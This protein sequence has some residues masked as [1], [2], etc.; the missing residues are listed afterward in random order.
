MKKATLILVL[1]FA[2]IQT[3]AQ[4]LHWL[5]NEGA[6]MSMEFFKHNFADIVENALK[7]Y[8][9][10]SDFRNCDGESIEDLDCKANDIIIYCQTATSYNETRLQE[11]YNQ[12][13]DHN[14]KLL[15]VLLMQFD[16]N[17][18]SDTQDDNTSDVYVA[19]EQMECIKDAF[20]NTCGTLIASGYSLNNFCNNFLVMLEDQE[21]D[22]VKLFETSDC[23][24]KA[25]LQKCGVDETISIDD[26]KKMFDNFIGSLEDFDNQDD[27]FASD[28]IVYIIAQDG[29][30]LVD[31]MTIDSYLLRIATS[32]VLQQCVP[33]SIKLENHLIKQL[34]P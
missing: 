20:S 33:L 2:T 25:Q 9:I 16:E 1:L 28:C 32:S 21:L 27:W 7:H 6:P 8:G 14:P 34:Y 11:V 13:V 18:D 12:L 15:I 5:F 30:T 26:L 23:E 29:S 4:K 10:D 24:Y 31:R 19:L 3:N 17:N 22:I